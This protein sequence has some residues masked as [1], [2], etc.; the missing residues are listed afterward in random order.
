MA[1][2][3]KAVEFVKRTLNK[4]QRLVTGWASVS[5]DEN[6]APVVDTEDHIVP[7]SELQS[8]VHSLMSAGGGMVGGNHEVEGLGP[9]VDSLVLTSDIRKALGMGAGEEGWLVTVR[10][11]DDAAWEKVKS[12]K[13]PAFSIRGEAELH[14]VENA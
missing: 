14:E 13:F 1:T 4:E 12:G 8:A 6:G 3:I 11:D 2:I 5:I 7:V 9:I 10:V